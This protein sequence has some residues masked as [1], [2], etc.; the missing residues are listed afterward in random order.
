MFPA[1]ASSVRHTSDAAAARDDD[2]EEEN[3]QQIMM[4]SVVEPIA[5]G[6]GASSPAAPAAPA[7]LAAHPPVA[8]PVDRAPA[9][10]AVTAAA[11]A[12]ADAPVVAEA[13]EGTD[14][15]SSA[16]AVV[17]PASDAPVDGPDADEA[18][19]LLD[20]GGGLDV[21]TGLGDKPAAYITRIFNQVRSNFPEF[22]ARYQSFRVPFPNSALM[23]I[24]DADRLDPYAS[25]FS[26]SDLLMWDPENVFQ[27]SFDKAK[28]L[29]CPFCKTAGA[30]KRRGWAPSSRFVIRADTVVL[31]LK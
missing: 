28:H 25:Y 19:E 27:H 22:L 16:G 30:L 29:R 20:D 18:A 23:P 9:T 26:S 11:A 13:I 5:A 3:E 12:D 2:E 24:K 15:A 4:T 17:A 10:G 21:A 6:Q 14:A 7:A 8:A 1:V 31:V